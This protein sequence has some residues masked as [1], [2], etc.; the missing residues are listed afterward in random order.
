MQ[1][2]PYL[3]RRAGVKGATGP[4]RV[5]EQLRAK[6]LGGKAT[7][8]SGASA[9]DK[10]DIVTRDYLLE[11]KTT[12]SGTLPIDV[13]WLRKISAEAVRRGKTPAL[14]VVYISANGRPKPEGA[15]VMIPEAVFKELLN[16]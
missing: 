11:V 9:G 16:G 15:W 1:G 8:Q 7:M 10:G 5:A 13:G 14:S 2:N 3:K 6:A 4:G 12:Q